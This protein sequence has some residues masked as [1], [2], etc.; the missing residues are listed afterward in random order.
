MLRT[1]PI[2]ARAAV[3]LA[4]AALAFAL[5]L[6]E[7]HDDDVGFHVANGRLVRSAWRDGTPIPTTNPFSYAAPDAPWP[8]HQELPAAGIAWLV[9]D[10]PGLLGQPA[11]PAHPDARVLIVVKALLVAALFAGL[12][13]GVMAE[14]APPALA[15]PLVVL[16]EAACA[17]RFYERPYLVSAIGLAVVVLALGAWRRTGR[18]RWLWL[19]AATPVVNAHLHAGFLDSMLAWA[20][21]VAG[22]AAAWAWARVVGGPGSDSRRTT[23]DSRLLLPFA[24]SIAATVGTLAAFAP[25]GLDA[26]LIP[27][28]MTGSETWHEHLRE[29]RP[30]W[31]GLP[32]LWPAAA[33]AVALAVLALVRRRDPG[34]AGHLRVWGFLALALRH[35]RM[36]LTLV[37]ATLPDLGR[38]AGGA[39]RA[40]WRPGAA[41]SRL[42]AA[43]LVTAAL[44]LAG[45]ALADQSE[46]F[47][48]GLDRDPGAVD[49][50]AHPF[51]LLDRVD[52]DGLPGEVFVSDGFAGTFLWR[53][54]PPRRVL[55][56]TV[57]ESY[58]VEVFRDVYQP[59]RYAAPGFEE[60]LRALGVRSFL[61]KHASPGEAREAAGR[62]T[63][64]QIL[65]ARSG[66]G[67]YPDAV[68]VD[69]DDAGALW[70]LRDA[71]PAGVATLD[72]FPVD[73]DSGAL[74]P[75]ADPDAAR[76]ALAAHANAHPGTRRSRQMLGALR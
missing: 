11:D 15:L 40:V 9:D 7:L 56:H 55:F 75:G 2:L 28:R 57:L 38:L 27:F 35:Q 13:A 20:A 39:L 6:F 1:P 5:S 25:S 48:M 52:R 51:A 44:A 18:R 60:R 68:L 19:A 53:L 26:A 71:L 63:L 10:A 46:R 3:V 66:T 62:P 37:V 24:A 36:V 21:E 32:A 50:T 14:G 73:P 23:C 17:T 8:Q 12:A 31:Q 41:P 43:C 54:Y 22:P 59:I 49:P 76:A 42:V 33:Y 64:R 58:P 61:L 30:L 65:A 70:V 16:G 74:R 29:F 4:A 69:F 47:R 45:V 72:G 67:V 34:A